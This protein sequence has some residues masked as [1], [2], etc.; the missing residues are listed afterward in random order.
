MRDA[1]IALLVGLAGIG[2]LHW[3]RVRGAT[4]EVRRKQ[5]AST[6]VALALLGAGALY[7]FFKLSTL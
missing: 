2:A 5:M 6:G 3:A 4:P 7:F 1:L